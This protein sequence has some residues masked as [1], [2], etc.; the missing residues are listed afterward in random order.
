MIVEN[1]MEP[2]E[3]LKKWIDAFNNA[4]IDALA[5]FYSDN[6]VNHQV[7]NEKPVIGKQA[8]KQMFENEFRQAKMICIPENIFQDDE[9]AILEWKD[10]LGFRGCGFFHIV[11]E[12]IIFQRGYW[13]KLTF[14][15]LYNND[16]K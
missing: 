11:D 1:K 6:A 10:P 4:D 13:D 2:K 5:N 14:Q 7:A 8:I 9:W 12:K 16:E 3:V 15:K